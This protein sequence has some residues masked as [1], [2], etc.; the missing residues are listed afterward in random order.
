MIG[1]IDGWMDGWMYFIHSSSPLRWLVL[2]VSGFL[3]YIL[4]TKWCK[5]LQRVLMR[6]KHLKRVLNICSTFENLKGVLNIRNP[7]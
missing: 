4:N 3:K 7:F 2:F 5:H 1:W 6:L